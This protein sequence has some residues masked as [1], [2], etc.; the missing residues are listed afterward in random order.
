MS[1]RVL[2]PL[3]PPVTPTVSTRGADELKKL[4]ADIPGRIG[5]P[6]GSGQNL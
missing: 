3:L 2:L 5:E 1:L 6:H 4:V